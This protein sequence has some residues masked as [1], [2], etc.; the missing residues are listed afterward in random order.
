[1]FDFKLNFNVRMKQPH[2]NLTNKFRTCTAVVYSSR[3]TDDGP[4]DSTHVKR[5]IE[6]ICF[7]DGNASNYIHTLTK[8]QTKL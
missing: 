1:M 5:A 4:C 7:C 6:S 3:S 2:P 8:Q